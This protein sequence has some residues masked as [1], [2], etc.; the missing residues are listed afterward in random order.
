MTAPQ[1]DGSHYNWS[2][3]AKFLNETSRGLTM[4]R[5]R[6]FNYI[7]E[8]LNSLAYRIEVCGKLNLL[9]LNIHSEAFFADLLNIVFGYDL[10]NLNIQKHNAEGIDLVDDKNKYGLIFSPNDD[11]LD[12]VSIL[13]ITLNMKTNEQRKLYDFIK[14]E[15]GDEIQEGRVYSNIA[16]IV[17]ILA[18]E[19]LSNTV[20]PPELNLFK[21]DEKI[22]FNDLESVKDAI[23]EHKVYY[24]QL[25]GIYSEFDRQ[26]NN[27]S[28]SVF[29]FIKNQYTRLLNKHN[30]SRDLFF[31]VIDTVTEVVESSQNYV[32]IP[33]GELDMCVHI[34]VVDAFIR[35]KVFKNPEGYGYAATR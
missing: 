15:L 4:N 14:A 16:A 27:K 25:N 33:Y 32:E 31:T 9:E 19:D 22:V 26:G 3:P 6:Y 21:I 2:R 10:R 29:R 28:I 23:D 35:C 1:L 5:S 11:V 24:S 17:D 13:R 12:I 8:K 34:L 30:D 20:E 18:R 7:Q